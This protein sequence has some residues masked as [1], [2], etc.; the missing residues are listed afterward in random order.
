MKRIIYFIAFFLLS[1]TIKI[2][3]QVYQTSSHTEQI[4]TLTVYSGGDWT[5]IPVIQTGT[6]NFIEVSFD[7]LSHENKRLAYRI[8]HCNADWKKSDMN[9]L[10]YLDGFPENDIE[11]GEQSISTL[12]L[13]T[14]YKFSLPNEKVQLKLSGNYAVEVYDRDGSG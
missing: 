8:I 14:H 12:T 1:V 5:S 2:Q 4:R 6:D 10:E 11:D 9:E 13:Y 3:A 7:E